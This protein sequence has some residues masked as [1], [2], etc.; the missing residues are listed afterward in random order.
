MRVEALTFAV[1]VASD[2]DSETV[3]WIPD[4][5]HIH[6]RRRRSAPV[7]PAESPRRLESLSE[8]SRAKDD[9]EYH[10]GERRRSGEL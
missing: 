4:Q 9:R 1:N 5:L 10:G 8:W 6:F 3:I 7:V 2:G